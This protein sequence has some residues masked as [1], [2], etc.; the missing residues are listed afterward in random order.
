MATPYS[1]ITLK[2]LNKISD[3]DL[4]KIAESLMEEVL[5]NY[6]FSACAKFRTSLIDL[7]DRDE[8]LEQFNITLTDDIIDILSEGMIAEWLKPSVFSKDNLANFLNHKDLA[9]AAS[10]A[11]ILKE[12]RTTLKESVA[13]FESLVIMYSY[14]NSD[15]SIML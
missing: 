8:V 14:N 10:P 3:P 6:M 5:F 2:F 12:A 13:D 7:S 1:T 11:N 15:A 9:L 4:L